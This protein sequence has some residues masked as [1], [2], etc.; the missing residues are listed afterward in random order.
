[1]EELSSIAAEQHK[2]INALAAAVK[3]QAAQVQKVSAQVE[4]SKTAP[5]MVVNKQ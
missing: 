1:V 5:Q 3:E 4:L 2:E